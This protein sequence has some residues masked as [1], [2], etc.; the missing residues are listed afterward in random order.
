MGA[1][2]GER[3]SERGPLSQVSIRMCA[4]TCIGSLP[5][6]SV[7]PSPDYCQE[8]CRRSSSSSSPPPLPRPPLQ[9]ARKCADVFQL[10]RSQPSEVW[11]TFAMLQV[12]EG[13]R[14]RSGRG[15]G[16]E[17]AR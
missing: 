11:R 6:A 5:P 16:G 4:Y 15:G 2:G 9:T 8:V 10:I 12:C 17:E 3:R 7:P 13:G 14:C 1:E